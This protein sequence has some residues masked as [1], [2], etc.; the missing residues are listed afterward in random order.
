MSSSGTIRATTPL[1]PWRPAIL[2]PTLSLRLLAMKTFT[3][4]M[5]PGSMSSPL[6][7]RSIE[8]SRSSSSCKLV[9][10]RSDDLPDLVPDRARVDLD[11]IVNRRQLAEQGLGDFAVRRDD[12]LA[13]LGVHHV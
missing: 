6:S 13:G 5:M 10:V 2:S 4:L 3:C 12:D 1:L 11:V 8:R 9:F 7:T